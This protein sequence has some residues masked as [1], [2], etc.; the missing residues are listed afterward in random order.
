MFIY[1]MTVLKPLPHCLGVYTWDKQL[2]GDRAETIRR[3]AIHAMTRTVQLTLALSGLHGPALPT[4][5]R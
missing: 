5:E 1:R 2:D 3:Q 4:A